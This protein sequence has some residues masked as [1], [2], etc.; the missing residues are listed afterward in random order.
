MSDDTLVRWRA[1]VRRAIPGAG[2]ELIEEVAQHAT[3]RWTSLQAEGRPPAG[4]RGRGAPGNRRMARRAGHAAAEALA[5]G[6]TLDRLDARRQ[7][8]RSRAARAPAVRVGRRP[9]VGDRDLGKRRG[10]R[11]HLRGALAA[12][13]VSRR[14]PA[15]RPLA[16]PQ[17]R[18][19]PGQLPGL[20]GCCGRGRVR[21]RGRDWRRARQPAYRRRDRARQHDRDGAGR[22]HDARGA[23]RA[24][25]AARC[26]RRRH[27]Q[28][29]RQPPAVARSA[30]FGSRDHRPVSLDQRPHL[31]R[32]RRAAGRDSTSSCRSRRC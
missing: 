9:A 5:A 12:I 8:R 3:D 19:G 16:G 11:G 20:L 6:A 7:I 17:R 4:M 23:P 27:T 15:R 22:L 25:T 24:R 10:V 28:P 26:R 30:R 18:A 14:R 1:A 21:R 31:H 32:R 2:D 29:A 13:A